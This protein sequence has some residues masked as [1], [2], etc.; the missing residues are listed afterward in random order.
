MAIRR[1]RWPTTS[2]QPSTATAWQYDEAQG[3][4]DVK[5]WLSKRVALKAVKGQAWAPRWWAVFLI[6]LALW[7][8]AVGSVVVTGDIIVLPTVFLLGSFLVPVTAVV[9]YLDHD[10][11]PVLSPMRIVTAFL[12]AGVLGLLAAAF[13]EYWLVYGPGLRGNLKVGLIE[14]FVKGV[15]I[16]A[17][18]VGLPSYTRRAGMVLGATVGFGFAALES[19]GY[20]LAA[21][22][23]VQG[24]HV[25]LS[26]SD[27]VVT[28][29]ARGVV[30]PFG[31]GLW[32][33]TLVGGL[34][35]R[36]RVARALVASRGIVAAGGSSWWQCL[37]PFAL[38]LVPGLFI[39]VVLARLRW[40]PRVGF[41]PLWEWQAPHLLIPLL[42]IL[43]L[44]IVGF[45][46]RG[47]M[48]TTVL[49]LTL[50]VGFVLISIFM[51]EVTYRGVIL[52]ALAGLSGVSRV[53]I[54][55]TLFGLSHLDNFF[56]PGADELGVAYQIFEA[57]LV[58]VL[59]GAVR[60]RM[61]AIWP[62]TILHA[63]YDLILV[64]P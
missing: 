15:A 7:G 64:L 33:A 1:T 37:V 54:S 8:A 46:A 38:V 29:L 49:V 53:A 40:W 35:A 36:F 20:A 10:P 12:V 62:V 51:E 3:A 41:T 4:T 13:L 17:L 59:F 48:A 18:A 24:Q 34:F 32:S 44:P 26:F 42:L 50:Q 45:S 23:V 61:N 55:A 19:S 63:T 31:H 60:L 9:W 14:E 25:T 39:A 2:L 56:L 28:E 11:S 27:V 47:M 57:A 6:G 21:L 43:V 58:G 16:V 52:Q 22:L 5:N 30:A